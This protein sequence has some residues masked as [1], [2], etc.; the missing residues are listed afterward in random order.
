MAK[1]SKISLTV[2]ILGNVTDLND[3]LKIV[4]NNLSK[5]KLP[6]N[7]SNNFNNLFTKLS[8]EIET[9]Q[10][11]ASST[12]R[13]TSDMRAIEKSGDK[14]I[15]LYRRLTM[16][17]Q[18]LNS[19]S[20]KQKAELIPSDSLNKMNK[21]QEGIKVYRSTVENLTKQEQK[22]TAELKKQEDTLK[23]LKQT[24]EQLKG[25]DTIPGKVAKSIKEELD[26]AIDAY[27]KAQAKLQEI[28]EKIE[29]DLADPTTKLKRNADGSLNKTSKLGKQY[30]KELAAAQNNVEAAMANKASAEEKFRSMP[31]T[32]S[33]HEN[34]LKKNSK[35]I[36][37]TEAAIKR[38]KES[39]AKIDVSAGT[40]QALEKLKSQ[41]AGIDG[42]DINTINSIEDLDKILQEL[43]SDA[44]SEAS[45]KLK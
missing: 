35:S 33:S 16:Q 15:D 21:L 23:R 14:I 43:A 31:K 12:I 10:S 8:K 27:N 2:D 7:I 18:N 36:A 25:E 30:S 20:D 39:I 1:N 38:I 3:S 11:K 24:R 40:T 34:D 37:E 32:V 6:T 22:E 41:L 29:R 9:F 28:N 13:T 45:E 44:S 42:I 4:Q 26:S 19:L 5:L 17:V